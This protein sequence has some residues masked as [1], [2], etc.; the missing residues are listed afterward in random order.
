M[1]TWLFSTIHQVVRP[2]T[3]PS[4][5][6]VNI[7]H[8][9]IIAIAPIAH[10]VARHR[11]QTSREVNSA[12]WDKFVPHERIKATRHTSKKRFSLNV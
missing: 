7:V 10:V 9:E 12:L 5:G 1:T 11:T 6:C 4:N 2:K 3:A 8:D